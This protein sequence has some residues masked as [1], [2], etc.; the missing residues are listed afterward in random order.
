MLRRSCQFLILVCL[1]CVWCWAANDPF[2][3]KW[4]LDASKSQLIDQMKVVDAGPNKY[5]FIFDGTNSETIVAD[6]TDQPGL[7][8]TTFSVTIQDPRTWK[9]VRKSE[10]RVV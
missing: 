4:M 2:V 7:A 9:V 8:G 3:G 5:T 10:G 1:S 6:G